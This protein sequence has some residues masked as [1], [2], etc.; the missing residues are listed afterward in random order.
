[1]AFGG[2]SPKNSRLASNKNSCQEAKYLPFAA[3]EAAREFREKC[4]TTMEVTYG[5]WWLLVVMSDEHSL[6]DC[7]NRKD[8]SYCY[9]SHRTWGK[10]QNEP[11]KR[12][13]SDMYMLF[14]FIYIW[15]SFWW[16]NWLLVSP[17][18]RLSKPMVVVCLIMFVLYRVIRPMSHPF[19]K[20]HFWPGQT[21][22][23]YR[24]WAQQPVTNGVK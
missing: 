23:D 14:I 1:M 5:I 15:Y 17:Y 8:A 19:L 11:V 24:R 3:G 18:Y 22:R 21:S 12:S 20:K 16:R 10:K 4:P 13:L 7:P 2:K 6:G 9:L